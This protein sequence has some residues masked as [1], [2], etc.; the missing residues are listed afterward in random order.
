MEDL[1]AAAPRVILD[2]R[3][4]VGVEVPEG[5]RPPALL[6]QQP[7]VP[8]A[9][10]RRSFVDQRFEGSVEAL[11]LQEGEEAPLTEPLHAG[12]LRRTS[13]LDGVP[14]L[15]GEHDGGLIV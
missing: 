1:G 2:E 5:V 7:Y 15:A 13:A 3:R 8:H 6:H 10:D 14:A 11:V 9:E 12:I 4:Q